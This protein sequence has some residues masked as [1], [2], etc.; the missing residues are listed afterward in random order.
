MGLLQDEELAAEARYLAA[1]R[2]N[3][4]GQIAEIQRLFAQG[5]SRRFLIARFGQDL[6]DL[7]IAERPR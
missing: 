4:P 2:A 5:S 1:L 3:Y 6:A 7:A